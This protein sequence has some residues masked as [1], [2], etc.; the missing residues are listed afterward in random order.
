MFAVLVWIVTGVILLSLV[1]MGVLALAADNPPTEMQKEYSAMLK[2]GFQMG[3]GAIVGLLG[4]RAAV[5]DT[6]GK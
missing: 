5:P 4:G 6:K 2:M 3:L 1:G